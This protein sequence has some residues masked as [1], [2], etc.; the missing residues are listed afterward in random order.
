MA[1]KQDHE[2]PEMPVPICVNT[3]SSLPL[4]ARQV[5]L[6]YIRIFM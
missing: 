2:R 5:V 3:T 1:N 6:N 4:F